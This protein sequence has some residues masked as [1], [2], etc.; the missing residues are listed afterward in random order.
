MSMK[1]IIGNNSYNLNS[2][3]EPRISSKNKTISFKLYGHQQ[4]KDFPEL[5]IL[6]K[7]RYQWILKG[8]E[9]KRILHSIDPYTKTDDTDI[10]ISYKSKS[11]SHLKESI[12]GEIR[13][14]NLNKLFKEV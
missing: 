10:T 12:K 13:D 3:D 2:W 7:F 1:I 11:G 6:D 9:L 14:W 8:C 4:F 5:I